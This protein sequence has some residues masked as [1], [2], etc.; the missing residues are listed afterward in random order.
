[1]GTPQR[2]PRQRN[3]TSGYPLPLLRVFITIETLLL[4]S[5]CAAT[6]V[7]TA[8][9]TPNADE[10]FRIS[11]IDLGDRAWGRNML[12][13]N[14]TNTTDRQQPFWLHI[15][16]GYVNIGRPSGFGMGMDEPIRLEPRQQRIIGHAYWIPPCVGKLSYK[17]KF[18]LPSGSTPP[19]EQEPFLTKPYSTVFDSPN[20]SCN[21][22]TPLPQFFKYDW[23]KAYRDG[24]RIVPFKTASTEHFVFYY[25]PDSPAQDD[26]QHIMTQREKT[27]RQICDFLGVDFTGSIDFFLFPDA[28]SKFACTMHTGDGLAHGTTIVEIYNADTKLDPA[29]EVTHIVASQIGSPP[30]L[31]NEGLAVYMQAGHMWNNEH[32]DTT[33]AKLRKQGKLS[34]IGQLIRRNEIGSQKGDGKITY[35]QS[36]SFVK[37]IIDRYGKDKFLKLYASLKAGAKDNKSRFQQEIGIELETAQNQWK[38]HLRTI[39]L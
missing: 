10:V 36:A 2:N 9:D 18:V 17:I 29:H 21:E 6:S 28:A 22:L 33:A 32:V 37:F 7:S 35:P 4:L 5:G 8:T 14:V 16:G 34:P 19:W 11:K 12:R 24:E 23:A 39:E 27:L 25:L 31:F 30:A 20:S 3:R 26:L 13:V 38:K 1:M 15:G